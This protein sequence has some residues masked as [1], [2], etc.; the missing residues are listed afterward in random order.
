MFVPISSASTGQWLHSVRSLKVPLIAGMLL[1]LT[2]I[3]GM[4]SPARYS[5]ASAA[6]AAHV[7]PQRALRAASAIVS[8]RGFRY[9]APASRTPTGPTGAC[10]PVSPAPRYTL[11]TLGTFVVDDPTLPTMSGQF[12]VRLL[13]WMVGGQPGTASGC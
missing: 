10:A 5:A 13:K 4:I 3:V 12:V 7:A 2:L 11:N 9:V 6:K 8:A 1:A